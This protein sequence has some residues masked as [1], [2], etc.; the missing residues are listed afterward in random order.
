MPVSL[1][2]LKTLT[3]R[4]NERIVENTSIFVFFYVSLKL[5]VLRV[6]RET[7]PSASAAV[8]VQERKKS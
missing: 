6:L 3:L 1:K 7:P 8:R 2:T 5:R 4:E